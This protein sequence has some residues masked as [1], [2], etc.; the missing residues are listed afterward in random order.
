M[1][2]RTV[3]AEKLIELSKDDDRIVVMEADLAGCHGTMA[4]KEA[5]PDRF[6]DCGIAEANMVGVAS[7]LAAA[8]KIPFAAS[9]APF[10]TRRA[11]DQVFI[12]AGYAKQNVKL[13]GSDPGINATMNGGTHMPFEDLALMRAVPESVIF[14]PSDFTSLKKIVE[15]LVSYNGLSYLRMHRKGGLT[16]YDESEVFEIGGSKV[17]QE[18]EDLTFITAGVNMVNF[19]LE[20]AKILETK[21]IKSTVIDL[22]C[23]KPFDRETVL[24]YAKLTGKVVTVD[25]HQISGGI[26]SAVAEYLSEVYPVPVKRIGVEDRFGQVGKLDFLAKEYGIDTDSIV[27]KTLKFLGK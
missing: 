10:I 5:Y 13:V 11:Y 18:G 6:I 7:G 17:L 21:G 4:F 1:D 23:I 20:A 9:F 15:E 22:Y 27:E 2:M 8:G 26:G 3:Y 24:K 14:E 19:T 25:N 16:R 12:S